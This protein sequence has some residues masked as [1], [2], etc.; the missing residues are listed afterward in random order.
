MGKMRLNWRVMLSAGLSIFVMLG[1]LPITPA[2][3]NFCQIS[4]LAYNYPQTVS[5]GQII[6]TAVTVSGVCAPDDAD[7]YT[8]RSD[9]ND[10]SGFILSDVSQPI[11]Y[12]QGQ[13]WT[14]TVQN[15]ITAPTGS[16]PWHILFAVYI[17]AAIGSGSI[18][19]SV[20]F[21]PVTIQVGS[22]QGTQTYLTNI[23]A[24]L[25]VQPS[26]ISAATLT[27]SPP[28]SKPPHETGQFELGRL[29]ATVLVMILRYDC[30]CPYTEM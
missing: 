6:N 18:I 17:F 13:N 29:F 26:T 8:I 14:I 22:S 23:S 9:L 25:Q 21:N 10:M 30:L 16:Y 15:R 19:D 12:S 4:N 11:G 27:S 5:P 3:A 24:T 28:R 7:F 1:T 20:F 2:F